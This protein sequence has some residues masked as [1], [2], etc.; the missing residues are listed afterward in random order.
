LNS[1]TSGSTEFPR[2]GRGVQLLPVP[3]RKLLYVIMRQVQA[4]T[5]RSKAPG[6]ATLPEVHETCGLE[7]NEIY[8]LLHT[9]RDSGLIEIVGDYPFEELKLV[10]IPAEHRI[11][12][13]GVELA[14]WEWPGDDPSILFCHGTGLHSRC[15]N[16]VIAQL[17]GRRCL[18]LDF[19]CHGRSA[20]PDPPYLWRT[21]GQDV[22]AVAADIGLSGAVGVGHS[23]GGHAMTLAA[24]LGPKA[25]SS[26]LLLDPVIRR[27]DAYVGPWTGARFVAKRRNRWISPREMFGRFENRPP[28]D[29]WDR[30]VLRDYCEYG[31]LAD[32][33]GFVLA[34]P[35]AVEAEIYENGPLSDADIYP[36]IATIRIPVQV[37]RAG[38][39]FDPTD[40][41]RNSPTTPDLASNFANG[42]D[43]SLPE[44]SHF[45]P[46]EAPALTARLIADILNSR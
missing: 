21:F 45:I 34:C 33:D 40:F 37:V 3:A 36:E 19:R 10:G 23:L 12:V 26:L 42:S 16:Q 39:H 18:A 1:N 13:G 2:F 41:M 11:S 4:G 38:K 25:F 28:F 24:A 46:M 29:S 17:A 30:A 32:G 6:I 20:K 9:L 27:R 8:P 35:P 22:A 14:L 5:L 44:H 31:L 43:L 15:W 7:V